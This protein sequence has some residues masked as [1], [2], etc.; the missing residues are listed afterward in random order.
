MSE[1]IWKFLLSSS[2]LGGLGL[3]LAVITLLI[4]LP[5]FLLRMLCA[6]K[7]YKKVWEHFRKGTEP[8]FERPSLL[9]YFIFIALVITFAGFAYMHYNTIGRVQEPSGNNLPAGK[10][11]S[12]VQQPL[13]RQDCF[14][15]GVKPQAPPPAQSDADARIELFEAMLSNSD[16]ATNRV[17]ALVTVLVAVATLIVALQFI[18][19]A[20]MLKEL[21]RKANKLEK[22]FVGKE[23]KLSQINEAIGKVE[24]FAQAKSYPIQI[25]LQK[26]FDD[27]PFFESFDTYGVWIKNSFTGFNVDNLSDNADWNSILFMARQALV[28]QPD[29][30]KLDN[31]KRLVAVASCKSEEFTGDREEKSI[32]LTLAIKT[33]EGMVAK[34]PEDEVNLASAYARRGMLFACLPKSSD[35][36][37]ADSI[38]G[39]VLKRND[40]SL[41]EGELR[42]K[43]YYNWGLSW[44]LRASLFK[45]NPE[46]WGKVP[47][48]DAK[49]FAEDYLKKRGQPALYAL[50][51]LY[52][53]S[54][55]EAKC[56]VTIAKLEKCF[57]ESTKSI[58]LPKLHRIKEDIDLQYIKEKNE[59]LYSRLVALTKGNDERERRENR[60]S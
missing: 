22:D 4:F 47:F 41:Q 54:E 11:N 34:E 9:S 38:F 36:K 48:N 28:S 6:C 33:F 55:D 44:L 49:Y 40:A 51:T 24:N 26:I 18:L 16:R 39:D 14:R 45:R 53:I 50:L 32:L 23:S 15:A 59:K 30:A 10:S 35:Y 29:N 31:I 60:S 37:E 56:E 2:F 46:E 17:F 58:P 3:V 7:D 42:D 27:K 21:E 12:F 43:A 57:D 1:G 52:C 8:A 13:A 20:R 5:K 25:S 19:N